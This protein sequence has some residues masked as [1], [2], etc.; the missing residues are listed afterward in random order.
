[1]IRN[2]CP[3]SLLLWALLANII[4]SISTLQI[5]LMLDGPSRTNHG[6]SADLFIELEELSRIVDIAYCVGLAGAGIQKPFSCAS[7]CDDFEGFELVTVCF[8]HA[9][10]PEAYIG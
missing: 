4:Q 9:P 3:W 8:Y 7:R 6:I 5:P 1:M 10:K 2:R